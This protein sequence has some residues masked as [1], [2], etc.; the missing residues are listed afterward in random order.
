[1]ARG[2][3]GIR[4]PR[5][6]LKVITVVIMIG[7]FLA[8]GC[9]T[10][11]APF[12]KAPLPS[13]TATAAPAAASPSPTRAGERLRLGFSAG[14][15]V[16]LDTG[17]LTMALN[18]YQAAGGSVMRFDLDWARI[19]PDGPN[20]WDWSA[21]DRVIDALVARHLTALPILDY[22]PA[23]ARLP[24]CT[25]EQCGPAD[26]DA[27]ATFAAAAATRY[28]GRGV[29]LWELWN[30]ENTSWLPAPDTAAYGR[31]LAK[32]SAAVH[33]VEPQATVLVGGLAPA[34]SVTGGSYS[35]PDFVA[36]LYALGLGPAFDGVAVHPYSFPALP[37]EP[38]GS[39]WNQMLAVHDVMVSKGD[40]AK[41]VYATEFGAPTAGPGAMATY[42]DRRFS[43]QPD[44]VDLDLQARTVD[45][46]VALGRSLPWLRMLLWYS[47]EDFGSDPRASLMSFGLLF[48]GGAP[49]PAYAHWQSAVRSLAG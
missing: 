49:K 43:S 31:L 33:R 11:T 9:G 45:R 29:T 15:L 5:A 20:G 44:H 21:T 24:G 47:L 30:E 10:S 8:S 42:A 2:L 39:G 25:S 16:G 4:K 22:T 37:G 48:S 28:A 38:S 34:E 19:Q 23:W 46:A 32:V 6:R 36:G 3:R 18:S 12:E 41:G 26:P 1:M 17:A 13:P 7:S 14:E 40:S 35:P 27:F